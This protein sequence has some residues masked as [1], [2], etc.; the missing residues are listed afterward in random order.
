MEG[1]NEIKKNYSL[2]LILPLIKKTDM[3]WKH[4]EST[5]DLEQLDKN[6]FEA[7]VLLYK[8]STRCS[9][10]SAAL[11]RIERKWHDKVPEAWFLDL[12]THR[13]ISDVIASRY[14]VQ[15]ESPQLLLI[16]KGVC[17]KHQSHMEVNVLTITG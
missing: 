6:S 8:H 2:A 14:G 11:S 13:D 9:I 16:S 3:N 1:I 12:I 7:P 17:I 4:I 15:H 10:S 5:E